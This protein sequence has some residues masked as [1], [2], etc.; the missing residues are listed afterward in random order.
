MNFFV[1]TIVYSFKQKALQI[2]MFLNK[3]K[4]VNFDLTMYFDNDSILMQWFLP[5]DKEGFSTFQGLLFRAN[6]AKI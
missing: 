1:V 4:K 6:L 3:V 2:K 5:F